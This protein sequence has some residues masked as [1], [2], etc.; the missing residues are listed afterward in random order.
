MKDPHTVYELLVSQWMTPDGTILRSRHRH[1]YVEHTDANGKTYFVDGGTDY[2]RTSG[3]GDLKWCGLHENDNFETIRN[4]WNWKSYGKNWEYPEG[5]LILLKDLTDE[6]I[7]NILITQNL[8]PK[9]VRLFNREQQYRFFIKLKEIF[10]YDESSPT[11]LSRIF[12]NKLRPTGTK[13]IKNND[14]ESLVVTFNKKQLLVHRVIYMLHFH[15]IQDGFI[16]D[17]ID[18]NVLNN[19][20]ENLRSVPVVLNTRNC[21][22]TTRNK[23][24]IQGVCKRIKNNRVY[25]RATWRTPDGKNKEKL[26][27][28]NTNPNAFE[29]ACAFRENKLSELNIGYTERHGK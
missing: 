11:F 20:I 3:Y 9:W 29:D 15:Y 6:H 17:H 12:K 7:E 18:G 27:C 1:D 4:T 28:E 14:V 2:I 21:K 23:S 24:G 25:Y 10:V 5:V 16:I 26:F 22:L 13:R 19:K 8:S